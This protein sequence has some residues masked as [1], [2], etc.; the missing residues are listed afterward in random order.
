VLEQLP[1]ER[2]GQVVAPLRPVE[3]TVG[4]AL[5]AARGA[6]HEAEVGEPGAAG[7]AQFQTGRAV[8][9]AAV[10]A[11][12]RVQRHAE[13]AGDVAVAATRVAQAAAL[14]VGPGALVAAALGDQRQRLQRVR[15]LG[16][17]EA[18]VAMAAARLGDQ[19]AGLRQFGEVRA[20]R[21]RLHAAGTRELAGARV[22]AV[23]QQRQHARA[24]G[25]GDHRR[26]ARQPRLV[27]GLH[28]SSP[29]ASVP[30]TPLTN[31]RSSGRMKR[32]RCAVSKFAR[33][34]GSAFSAVR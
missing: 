9:Q 13:P 6:R 15:D 27:R 4:E 2:A 17:G 32:S 12:A 8:A 24:R 28:A 14:R 31:C 34:S 22:L 11:Q 18:E 5:P 16:V 25:V 1:A 29:A 10:V 19:Q 26:D 7:V 3:A 33:P 30:G 21:R 23:E 20:G